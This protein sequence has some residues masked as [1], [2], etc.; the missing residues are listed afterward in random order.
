MWYSF[1]GDLVGDG[2]KNMEGK[3]KLYLGLK[4]NEH[5]NN[6]KPKELQRRK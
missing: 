3:Y 4:Y 5:K 6:K 1:N 2:L